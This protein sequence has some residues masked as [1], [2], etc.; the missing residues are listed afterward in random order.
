MME[1]NEKFPLETAAEK[2]LN[3]ARVSLKKITNYFFTIPKRRDDK[4]IYV[5]ETGAW[6]LLTLALIL[7]IVWR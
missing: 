3:Q 4:V 5:L 1:R 6:L 2:L 7:R